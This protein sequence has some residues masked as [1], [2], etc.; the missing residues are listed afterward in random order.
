[1]SPAMPPKNKSELLLK[2]YLR[3]HG[4]TDF[5]FEPE[6]PGTTR[7]PDYRLHWP[8]GELLLR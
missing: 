8:G 6:I 5:D 3:S 2:G 7:R 4:Y 1:M